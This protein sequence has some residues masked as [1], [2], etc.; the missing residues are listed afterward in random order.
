MSERKESLWLT[1]DKDSPDRQ[2]AASAQGVRSYPD[3]HVMKKVI[4]GPYTVGNDS[5]PAKEGYRYFLHSVTCCA[6]ITPGVHD[7]TAVY[8]YTYINGAFT[9]LALAPV[10]QLFPNGVVSMVLDCLT[11]V[12]VPVTMTL[13]GTAIYGL[14]SVAY[15]LVKDGE[16]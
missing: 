7:A 14:G 15:A 4:E 8:W 1:S 13:N 3:R 5:L 2:I 6:A 10:T 9:F 12:N 16:E 11:D